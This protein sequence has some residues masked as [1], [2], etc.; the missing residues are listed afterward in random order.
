MTTTTMPPATLAA[1]RPALSIGKRMLRRRGRKMRSWEVTI[2]RFVVCLIGRMQ[3]GF[4]LGVQ[5]MISLEMVAKIRHTMRQLTQ[6]LIGN[7][8]VSELHIT[9]RA[10]RT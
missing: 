6:S 3:C 8:M 1:L 7:A 5:L 10:S 9:C 4:V 2:V